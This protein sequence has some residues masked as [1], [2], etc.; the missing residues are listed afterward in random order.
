MPTTP[1]KQYVCRD[2]FSAATSEM[3]KR[4]EAEHAAAR[5]RLGCTT[6]AV[7]RGH[8]RQEQPVL[9]CTSWCVGGCVLARARASILSLCQAIAKE[10]SGC[11]LI[12]LW[13]SYFSA[14]F[15]SV[16]TP[17]GQSWIS[18]IS[19]DSGNRIEVRTLGKPTPMRVN[20]KRKRK[21]LNMTGK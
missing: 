9:A 13:H 2:F 18:W 8:E 10:L 6:R 11:L 3:I 20:E 14:L 17:Q 12:S 5:Q 7:T 19:S 15:W 21:K 1:G 16:L 4:G